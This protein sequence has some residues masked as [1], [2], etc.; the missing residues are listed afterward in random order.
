[1]EHPTDLPDHTTWPDDAPVAWSEALT[2]ALLQWAY[3]R[4]LFPW[5]NP[6]EP[7]LWW[8]PN[9]RMV[10]WP[11]QFYGGKNLAKLYHKGPFT[12]SINQRFTEVM[13]A[14]GTTLR[15]GQE[16]GSWIQPDLV[17]CYTHLHRH[18]QAL[19]VEVYQ[20]TDLVGGLYGVHMGSVFFGE[21]MFSRMPNT[22]K[23]ALLHLCGQA[24]AL[25]IKLIDCQ[26]YTDHLASLGAREMPRS[27][28]LDHL[29]AWL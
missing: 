23:L 25:N 26:V 29:K 22:S 3:P 10:L 4:S 27:Q 2:P 8:S 12:Y 18:H 20:G 1:M 28:F 17:A 14:C 9:P 19:S 13:E 11:D 15:P 16:G 24:S 7:V 6:G 21:S 5:Y